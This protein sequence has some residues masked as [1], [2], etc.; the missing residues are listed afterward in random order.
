MLVWLGR[1]ILSAAIFGLFATAAV[2]AQNVGNQGA[3]ASGGAGGGFRALSSAEAAFFVLPDDMDL[4]TSTRLGRYGLTYERYQQVFGSA[5]VLGG[6]LTLYRDDSG[7]VTT[8]IGAHYPNIAPTNRVRL[9]PAAARGIVDR[10]VGPEGRRITDLMI[11]PRSGRYFFRVETRRPNSRW[12]LWIGAQGGQVINKYNALAYQTCEIGSTQCGIG[13]ESDVKDLSG[14]STWKSKEDPPVFW[15]ESLDGRLGT[16]DQGSFNCSVFGC[17]ADISTD[18]DDAWIEPGYDSPGQAALVDAQ[19]YSHVTDRYFLTRH[20]FD[21]VTMGTAAGMPYPFIPIMAHYQ[22]NFNNAFWNG[23]YV[24]LGDGDQVMFR[25]LTSLDVIA[26]ELTHGVTEF[27]SD[28]IPQ[29]ESGALSEAF[30]DIMAA[31]AEFYADDPNGDGDTGDSLEPGA[32][33]ADLTVDAPLFQ[34]D[35]LMG[36]EFD[37]RPDTVPG[38]RNMGDPEEDDDP[39]HYSERYTGTGDNG[40]VHTNSGIPNHAYY[41]LVE[42]GPNAG[43]DGSGSIHDHCKGGGIGVDTP[44]TG[45]EIAD[46]ERV[47]FLAFTALNSNAT[48]C[49]ARAATEAIA[50]DNAVAVVD[51]DLSF[52]ARLQSTTDAWVAVGLTNAVCP[53]PLADNPPT[54]TITQPTDG[55]EVSGKRSKVVADASDDNGV[56]RV[57]FLINEDTVCV[58]SDG[59]NGWSCRWDTKV[60]QDGPYD[61]IARA[62][63]NAAQSMQSSIPITVKNSK[64]GDD[65]GGGGGG[66]WT[67]EDK[68]EHKSCPQQ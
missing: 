44:V 28:Q 29:N 58:D 14:L 4:V 35:W 50:I 56:T 61:L 34:P 63:D 52:S 27:T 47:F 6:Q 17:T 19:Y 2:H 49:D 3:G 25:E 10:D 59:S 13:V 12:I 30:S 41:L 67:C 46:A 11:D 9:T 60:Y 22:S 8:V 26:H 64:D 66:K 15:L 24:A 31:S 48:M 43:C 53:D 5:K 45:I 18:A 57:E 38:F 36:E 1:V 32:A 40:G 37:L 42:G 39:D 65:G 55:A 33:D 51:Q 21:W 7:A 68:P 23:S 20:G 16:Y 62:W 54:V